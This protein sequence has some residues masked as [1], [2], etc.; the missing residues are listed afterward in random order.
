MRTVDSIKA[1]PGVP[2]VLHGVLVNDVQ[3]HPRAVLGDHRIPFNPQGINADRAQA[4]EKDPGATGDV[5]D[6]LAT[7]KKPYI[8]I[9][10]CMQQ[11][12]VARKKFIGA[13]VK[14]PGMLPPGAQPGYDI[15]P[16]RKAY[17]FVWLDQSTQYRW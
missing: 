4:V 9:L 1:I 15:G 2:E 17:H 12:M 3:A 5:Q 14:L 7:G 11:G 8:P 13:V 10:H 16:R 6:T